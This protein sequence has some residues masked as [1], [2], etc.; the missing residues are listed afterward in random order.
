M[1]SAEQDKGRGGADFATAEMLFVLALIGQRYRLEL[2]D[3]APV[4]MVAR[5]TL[6]P[7]R[8]IALRIVPRT[9]A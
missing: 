3:P 9:A 6:A 7:A 4:D 2:A 5:I 8:E 1:R